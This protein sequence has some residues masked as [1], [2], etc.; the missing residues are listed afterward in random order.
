M[1]PNRHRPGSRPVATALVLS[2]LVAL[3][4]AC[5][6]GGPSGESSNGSPKAGQKIA[7]SLVA[8]FQQTLDRDATKLSTFEK[9]VLTRAVANG[10][11]ASIDYEDAFNRRN[12]CMK[13]AGYTDKAVKL[14]NGLYKLSPAI[15]ADGDAQKWMEAWADADKKCAMGNLIIIE[16]LYRIQQGNSDL[17]ADPL[18]VA[19]RC[20][21]KEGLAPA[22]YTA[23]ELK[24]W[25]ETQGKQP[26]FDPKDAKAQVCFS[27]AG[28]AVGI[29]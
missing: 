19:A 22:T 9:D 29:A 3:L 14:P 15:P 26:P 28:I 25:L 5:S 27:N 23:K 1:N 18:E 8:L 11:I 16:S 6:L 13:D 20:L 17:L 7:P 4:G 10:K 12:T 24:E 2:V 21:V